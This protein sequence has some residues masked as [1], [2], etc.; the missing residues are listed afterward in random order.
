MLKKDKQKVLDEVWDEARIRSFLDLQPSAGENPDFHKLFK[1]YQSM[2]AEDFKL[3]V[4]MFV[5]GNCDI[6]AV[7][8]QGETV[9][10]MIGQHRHA[11]EFIEA[12]KAAGAE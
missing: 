12:L 5:A 3:F 7:G 4:S 11:G 1:A 2:R 10:A 9:L 6:N 8:E